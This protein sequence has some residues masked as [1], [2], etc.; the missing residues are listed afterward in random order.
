[1]KKLMLTAVLFVLLFA[2]AATAQAAETGSEITAL[3]VE[4]TVNDD[5]TY[6]IAENISQYAHE[7]RRGIY[8]IF[9][10]SNTETFQHNGQE[11]QRTYNVRVGK[12]DSDTHYEIFDEDGTIKIRLGNADVTFTGERDYFLKYTYTNGYDQLEDFDQFNYNIVANWDD[13]VSDVTFKITMP[14][15]FDAELVG[16]NTGARG[17]HGY[18]TERLS[19][20]V[21]GNVI[22][23]RFDGTINPGEALTINVELPEG[24]FTAMPSVKGMAVVPT[25]LI[26]ALAAIAL[27]LL[28]LRGRRQRPVVTVEFNPPDGLTSADIGYVMDGTADDKDIL[29]L[30][31]YWADKGCLEIHEE[32]KKKLK[33]VKLKDLPPD[34]NDYET[35]VFDKLFSGRDSVST[36]DLEKN[37]YE[38]LTT[39]KSRVK[40]KYT[41]DENQIFSKSANALN[42]VVLLLSIL[43]VFVLSAFTYYID[44]FDIVGSVVIALLVL[45]AGMVLG[46]IYVSI[47]R[48]WGTLKASHRTAQLIITLIL[49]A[50]FYGVVNFFCRAFFG[51][52]TILACVLSALILL[53]SPLMLRRTEFGLGLY[54]RLLGFKNFISTVEAEKLKML[55]EENPSYFYNILPYAYVMG[56]SDKWAKRFESIAVEPPSWYYGGRYDTFTTVYFTSALMRSMSHAQSSMIPRSSSSG[57]GFTTG[58]SGGGGFGGGGFSGGGGGGGGGSW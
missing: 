1:M 55:V 12:V 31:I 8:R 21:D 53:L 38:T 44:T 33:L 39:A 20:T 35:L 57:G 30:F 46:G 48:N 37:F 10:S 7:E 16:F 5:Y 32:D 17:M 49:L 24:Y 45:M 11:M 34:A 43:L 41:R 9:D 27:I 6:D 23:G 19:F 40:S 4:I 56:I 29:S 42:G 25:I 18:D 28:A 47:I 26:I 14:H 52:F 22:E 51:W 3:D 13:P 2:C 50:V 54:G 58:G 15:E 36:K